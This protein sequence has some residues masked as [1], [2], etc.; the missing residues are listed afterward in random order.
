MGRFVAKMFAIVMGLLLQ[1]NLSARTT[2]I[3]KAHATRN[4]GKEDCA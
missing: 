4:A 1:D 3:P 2:R